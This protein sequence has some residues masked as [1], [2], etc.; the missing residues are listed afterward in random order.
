M[1]IG[2]RE[3]QGSKLTDVLQRK[4]KARRQEGPPLARLRCQRGRPGRGTWSAPGPAPWRTPPPRS[5]AAAAAPRRRG[6]RRPGWAAG[7]RGRA[8]RASRRNQRVDSAEGNGKQK[9]ETN[10][11][12]DLWSK[13]AIRMKCRLQKWAKTR[14]PWT[15]TLS[16][17][18]DLPLARLF[19]KKKYRY[20]STGA[21]RP[22]CQILYHP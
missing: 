7:R 3:N 20:R 2:S 13:S 10:P 16:L 9:A 18:F 19:S 14:G 22:L 8:S 21:C 1:G 4:G 17:K 5:G 11:G 12:E 6:S 15:L